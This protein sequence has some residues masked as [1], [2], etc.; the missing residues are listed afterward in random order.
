MN[1][2]DIE[3]FCCDFLRGNNRQLRDIVDN[4]R[5]MLDIQ[6]MRFTEDTF[7]D[8]FQRI[9]EVLFKH[10]PVKNGYVIAM[11]GL[12]IEIND[13]HHPSS[14]YT[15]D[16]LINSMTSVLEEIDFNPQQQQLPKTNYCILL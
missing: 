11:L 16:I 8:S 6:Q 5:P 9:C 13:Y 2:N 1:R 12:A 3:Q 7:D 15:T 4:Y 10:R 14:W